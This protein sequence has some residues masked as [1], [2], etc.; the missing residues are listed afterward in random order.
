MG[1]GLYMSILEVW[2]TVSKLKLPEM[3]K[4][5]FKQMRKEFT[6]GKG[7]FFLA[8]AKV[9]NYQ[10]GCTYLEFNLLNSFSSIEEMFKI[11]YSFECKRLI[12]EQGV[13]FTPYSFVA[14][15]LLHELGHAYHYNFY[16]YEELNKLYLEQEKELSS[17]QESELPE[18]EIQIKYRE[19][20]LEKFAD[21]FALKHIHSFVNSDG[22]QL[23][24]VG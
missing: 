21:N 20:P 22:E 1:R 14:F 13:L 24:F 4:V 7:D 19:F 5:H 23:I 6:G 15:S 3:N 9:V 2:E 16:T 10:T 18:K 17:Y 8:V 12:E 11:L